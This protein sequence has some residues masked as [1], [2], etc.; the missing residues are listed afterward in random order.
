M[1]FT[2]KQWAL[3]FLHALG[4]PSP[5]EGTV[6]FVLGWTRAE[7]GGGQGSRFNL[8]NTTQWAPGATNY[9]DVGVKNYVSYQQGIN[10]N[11]QTLRNGLYPSLLN[12]LLTNNHAALGASGTPS[13]GVLNNLS[14]W[15]ACGYGR[16]FFTTGSQWGGDVFTYANATP[17]A[18]GKPVQ[19]KP[20]PIQTLQTAGQ[21]AVNEVNTTVTN[22]AAKAATGILNNPFSS[23]VGNLTGLLDPVRWAKAGAGIIM[24]LAGIVLA[25]GILAGKVESSQAVQTAQKGLMKVGLMSA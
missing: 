7:T 14:T 12:A 1:A 23:L 24:I 20:N 11:V 6:N 9:N 19:P 21:A 25:I 13:Q 18:G 3:D 22:T 2:R 17:I 10:A 4:N 15:C 16:G 5:S 8:L